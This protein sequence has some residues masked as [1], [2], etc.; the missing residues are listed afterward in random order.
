MRIIILDAPA[1]QL[2]V[3][4]GKGSARKE[5]RGVFDGVV[6]GQHLGTR[7]QTRAAKA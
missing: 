4:V 5:Q 1:C 7:R 6:N 3:V 2:C